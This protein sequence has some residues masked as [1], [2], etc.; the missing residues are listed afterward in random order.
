MATFRCSVR[1]YDV[2]FGFVTVVR[3][4]CHEFRHVRDLSRFLSIDFCGWEGMV[5]HKG[6]RL[7]HPFFER[8]LR[9]KQKIHESDLRLSC[10]IHETPLQMFAENRKKNPIEKIFAFSKEKSPF[11]LTAG[12]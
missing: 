2:H 1:K 10:K 5:E 11:V 9:R 4:Y 3:K 12:G 6:Q 7:C 8:D